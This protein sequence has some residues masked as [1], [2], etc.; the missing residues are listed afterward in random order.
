[1]L[2]PYSW[3]KEFVN[4]KI[5]PERVGERLS[6]TAIGVESVK[7]E[8]KERVLD[9][10]VTFNRGDLL[11]IIG[12]AREIAALFNLRLQGEE[13]VIEIPKGIAK[14]PIKGCGSLCSL[15]TLTQVSG[16]SYQETP[17][18]IKR[19]LE[20][21]GMRAVNLFADITNYVML[22]YG[23]PLHAFDL[24][25]IKTRSGTTAIEVRNAKRGE[26][27]TLID[28]S[29]HILK[30]SDIVIADRRGPIA[31]AGVMGGKDTEVDPNT[32]E[33]L[34]EAAIFNPTAI[35]RTARRLGLQ[36]E[37]SNRFEHYLSTQNTLQALNK[38]VKLYRLHGKGNLTAFG[39]YGEPKKDPEP[40]NLSRE[41]MDALLGAKINI[42][43][44]RQYLRR[45]GFKL[46]S[47]DKGLLVWPPHFRGDIQI[48]E[49]L[50]E[51]V[52]RIYGYERLPVIS[53][54]GSVTNIPPNIL[55]ELRRRLPNFLAGMGF[56][57]VKSYPFL[58][59]EALS[60]R[61]TEGV[62]KVRN[63]ISAEAEYLKDSNLISLLEA[64]R[65]N[66]PRQKEGKLLELEKIYPQTGEYFSLSAVVWGA[67]EPYRELKG[68]LEALLDKT[69]T[70]YRFIPIQDALLHPGKAASIAIQNTK[71]G[72]IG[73][74]HPHLTKSYNLTNAAIFEINLEELAKHTERWGTFTPVSKYPEV[75]EDFSFYLPPEKSL[76]SLVEML[77]TADKVIREVKLSD[78]FEKDRKRSVTLR[79]VFQSESEDL[80]SKD[81]KPVRGKIT[82]LIKKS[83]GEPRV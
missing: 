60:H 48:E 68:I 29:T 69:H 12:V 16:L 64:A 24:N 10:E 43:E 63:P 18:K 80:S 8:G 38:A 5:S 20:L 81:I 47:S 76:G 53:P 40:V 62:L 82:K 26:E 52:A 1:M 4:I 65:R 25:K 7:K 54:S 32:K 45:L 19:C 3:I 79:V 74:P 31:I 77:R 58:S 22:E 71:I 23:Q 51:E 33:I 27:I 28:G 78:L 66:A 14:L 42:S 55:E 9:L 6:C 61:G 35:R 30:T 21:S 46:M 73:E 56:S 49:D 37:A 2:V 36:S 13:K 72:F 83:G 57:E 44:A 70:K 11:S 17:K 39:Q 34:L 67:K 59:T 15:Y 75:Y 41:K 50:I